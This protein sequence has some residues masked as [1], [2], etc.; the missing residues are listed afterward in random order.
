VRR[1]SL[2]LV[3]AIAAGCGS[4]PA[5]TETTPAPP[6]P[7]GKRSD[8]PRVYLHVLWIFMENKP[9]DRIIG[10]RDAPTINMIARQCGLATNY[11][12]ITHPSL[13]NYI[14]ATSGDTRG[15]SDDKSPGSHPLAVPSIYGQIEAA[16]RTWRDY[17]ESVPSNCP[18]HPSGRYAVKHDPAPYYTRIAATCARWDVSLEN[19]SRDLAANTLP[20]FAFVTPDLC[21][22][23]HDCSVATGD[24]W[25]RK[26]LRAIVASRAYR[27]GGTAVFLTWDEDDRSHSNHIATIVI[28]PYTPAGTKSPTAFTHYSLLKTTEQMLGLGFIGH[29]GDAGT[30]SMRA[31]FGL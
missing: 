6:D 11:T 9:Y 27:A 8:P 29:A 13:P 20:A 12:A 2:L 4:S 31:A 21:N 24:L 22:D 30:N 23:M 17:A 14:A 3:I 25:L 26:W 15:I 19:L 18:S 7:C 16:G 1:L 28:S 5:P 10:S